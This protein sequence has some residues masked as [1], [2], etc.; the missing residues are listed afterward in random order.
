MAPTATLRSRGHTRS[1]AAGRESGRCRFAPLLT[2]L[3][4]AASGAAR[5]ASFTPLADFAADPTPWLHIY[6]NSDQR[7]PSYYGLSPRQLEGLGTAAAPRSAVIVLNWFLQPLAAINAQQ[8]R[9]TIAPNITAS[10]GEGASAVWFEMWPSLNDYGRGV[11]VTPRWA[12]AAAGPWVWLDDIPTLNDTA[13]F[14]PAPELP[15]RYDMWAPD[16]FH[17]VFDDFSVMPDL[18]DKPLFGDCLWT[19]GNDGAE[20]EVYAGW[21]APDDDTRDV[22]RAAVEANAMR[23]ICRLVHQPARFNGVPFGLLVRDDFGSGADLLTWPGAV[24][25]ANVSWEEAVFA[26]IPGEDDDFRGAAPWRAP[27]RPLWSAATA[28][29]PHTAGWCGRTP[30]IAWPSVR[31]FNASWSSDLLRLDGERPAQLDDG[32]WVTLDNKN[33]GE[34]DNKLLQEVALLEQWYAALGVTTWRQPFVWR[35]IAQSNLVAV[36]PAS[37]VTECPGLD[38]SSPRPPVVMADHF[39]TAYC[40]DIFEQTGQRVATNGADD[41]TSASATLLAAARILQSLSPCLPVW[42]LH[43]TGD[44]PCRRAGA[45]ARLTRVRRRALLALAG[46]VSGEE[47]PGDCLGARHFVSWLLQSKTDITGLVLMDMIG[48]GRSAWRSAWA[49]LTQR[50]R[51]VEHAG[52]T[53]F[54]IHTGDNADSFSLANVVLQAFSSALEGRL[55]YP[56]SPVCPLFYDPRNFAFQVLR[57]GR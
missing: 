44:V 13:P 23:N 15:S 52:D 34:A 11:W 4:L 50:P 30:P 39:D 57:E 22:Y 33:A 12:C 6:G 24:A 14:T 38:A 18:Y 35:G 21:A 47:F 2:L 51:A 56:I 8:L 37:D 55:P 26:E 45:L 48:H 46:V 32:S 49:P 7:Q 36:L 54:Q 16:D 20:E 43:L 40:E 31:D 17:A 10:C 42:L 19:N 9:S 1:A 25:W 3:A 41:N 29:P 53:V 28:C 5:P 27:V